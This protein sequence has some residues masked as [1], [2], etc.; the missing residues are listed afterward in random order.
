LW[1]N[2]KIS[3]IIFIVNPYFIWILVIF[4]ILIYL[5]FFKKRKKTII[6]WPIINAPN[7]NN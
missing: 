1:W 7:I 2:F 3:K 5:A 4:L 6:T